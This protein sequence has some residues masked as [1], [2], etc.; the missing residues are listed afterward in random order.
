MVDYK[1]LMFDFGRTQCRDHSFEPPQ[2]TSTNKRSPVEKISSIEQQQQQQVKT[3]SPK[4]I[5]RTKYTIQL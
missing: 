2:E 5:I 1:N 4:D 3:R